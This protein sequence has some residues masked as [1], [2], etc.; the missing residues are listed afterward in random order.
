MKFAKGLSSPLRELAL[1][2][3]PFGATFEGLIETALLNTT[4]IG[5]SNVQQKKDNDQGKRKN[6]GNE[7]GPNKK[8]AMKCKS[9][10][11]RGHETKDCRVNISKIK[12]YNCNQMGHMKG[13][14]PA[15]A[16]KGRIAM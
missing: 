11:I 1:S 9:C 12:C 2:Q 13:E 4:M 3:I 8:Q 15:L 5:A 7:V 16:R 6:F 10:N 14:C